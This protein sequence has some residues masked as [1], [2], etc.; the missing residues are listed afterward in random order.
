MADDIIAFFGN[1][2]LYQLITD[3]V[4]ITILPPKR[5]TE[6]SP[7]SAKLSSPAH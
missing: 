3:L 7:I 6:D 5:P 4:R 1:T 2:D